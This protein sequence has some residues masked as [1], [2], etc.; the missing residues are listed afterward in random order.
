MAD[1]PDTTFFEHGEFLRHQGLNWTS[2]FGEDGY[3][4]KA[5]ERIGEKNCWCFEVGAADGLYLSNTKRLR[6]A[7][8][9]AVLI[10]ANEKDFEK[11]REFASDKVFVL[12]D[13]VEGDDLDEILAIAGA[14]FDLDLGVIDI[15]GQDYYLW[16]ELAAF[17]PRL[18]LIEYSPYGSPDD[19][20]ALNK[21][22]QAG[23]NP[24]LAMGQAKGY[25]PLVQTYCNVLF[26][27]EDQWSN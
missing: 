14:P 16:D 23:L 9:N 19:L 3:I 12:L 5:L 26:V 20:P 25:L 6:D 11:L 18:L 8:W 7:G 22:G 2:Q 4:E 1:H 21:P 10:E 27:R 13:R 24:I 15:D 17:R